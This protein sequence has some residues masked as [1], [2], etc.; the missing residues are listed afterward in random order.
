MKLHMIFLK[1]TYYQS[2]LVKVEFEARQEDDIIYYF[3]K[4]KNVELPLRVEKLGKV[5]SQN[6]SSGV[7][8][9]NMF[10]YYLDESKTDEMKDLVKAKFVEEIDKRIDFYKDMKAHISDAKFKELK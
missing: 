2:C 10:I 8:Y 5:K 7:E 9:S 3:D 1:Y 6:I 4:V